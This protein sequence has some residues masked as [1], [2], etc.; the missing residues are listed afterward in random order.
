MQYQS[1]IDEYVSLGHCHEVQVDP[2][3]EDAR[4]SYYLPHH[5][6]LNPNSSTTKLRVVFDASSKTSTN[7]SLNDIMMNGPV[8]QDDLFSIIMRFSLQN[9]SVCLYGR[10]I[11]DVSTS[12][13]Q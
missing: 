8:V 5:C 1:F 4:K 9:I 6:V 11:K 3:T 2:A 10:L 7:Y 12:T 13:N